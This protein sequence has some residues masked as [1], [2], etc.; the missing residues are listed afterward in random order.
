VPEKSTIKTAFKSCGNCGACWQTRTEFIE[1][2]SVDLVGYQSNFDKIEEGLFLFN[3][4]IDS[5]GST[6]A[7]PV[8]KFDD[9]YEGE[10]YPEPKYGRD[11]CQKRCID[12][13]NL[14]RCDQKCKYAYVREILQ[15]LK[16]QKG[17][18]QDIT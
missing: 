9:L 4:M 13:F 6:L 16:Y 2:S 3:H 15:I 18:K 17:K 1:C 12:R 8:R 10:R 14:E 11:E 5:C 7:V